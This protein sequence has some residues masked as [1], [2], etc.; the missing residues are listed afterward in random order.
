VPFKFRQPTANV[1]RIVD[2]RVQRCPS[3]PAVMDSYL[4]QSGCTYTWTGKDGLDELSLSQFDHSRRASV[5]MEDPSTPPGAVIHERIYA[6][7]DTLD[8]LQ[9][10]L[11]DG[12]SPSTP[13]LSSPPTTYEEATSGGFLDAISLEKQALYRFGV[14]E[15]VAIPAGRKLLTWKWIFTNKLDHL[16][17]LVRRKA[18]LCV[19]GF[20]QEPGLDYTDTF[21]PTCRLRCFR[22][23]LAMA[24]RC[25]TVMVTQLDVVSAFLHADIDVETYA[26]IPAGLRL[27]GD[28]DKCFRLRKSVYGLKQ[29]SRLFYKLLAKT[30]LGMG[31]T[32]S[33]LDECLFTKRVD[34]QFIHILVHVDDMAVFHNSTTLYDLTLSHLREIFELKE[35]GPIKEFL[36]LVVDRDTSGGL[37]IHQAPYVHRVMDKLGIFPRGAQSPMRPGSAQKLQPRLDLTPEETD[38]MKSVP[39]K[40]AVGALFY[41]ARAT[42]FDIAYSCTQL[43][44]FMEHPAPEHWD[45]VL[46]VYSYLA[47]TS[48]WTLAMGPA[49]P[50]SMILTASSDSDWAGCQDTRRSHTGWVVMLGG[51][52]VAWRSKRQSCFAQSVTEAEYVAA[53]D[54]CNEIVWWRA[55]CAEMDWGD[56]VPTPLFVDNDATVTLSQHSGKFEATKHIELRMHSIRDKVEFNQISVRWTPGTT[57]IADVLTKQTKCIL[58]R[59]LVKDALDAL[60]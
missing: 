55:L 44:R 9:A 59:Q 13:P 33:K 46:R 43:A 26:E 35:L 48:H 53:N 42:R 3:A 31:F 36:G 1:A 37:S 17:N 47:A 16:G 4:V 54:A 32:Q 51:A 29:A 38:F 14:V 23:L 8:A 28:E 56:D 50:N 21:A 45:A 6:G 2:H 11:F 41:V 49:T 18:R 60:L 30:L 57:N 34:D 27:P 15:R 10:S 39:Y 52:V 24:H 58:F 40:S 22:A 20:T 12:D 5:T 7:T 19:R 25:P